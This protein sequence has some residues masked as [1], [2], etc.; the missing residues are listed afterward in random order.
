MNLKNILT[1]EAVA[2]KMGTSV[3]TV[4]SWKGLGMPTVKLGKNV[5]ILEGS[6]TR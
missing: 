1:L 3:K 6:F 4:L 2:K 5:F